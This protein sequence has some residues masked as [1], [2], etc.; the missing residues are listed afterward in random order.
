M[1]ERDRKLFHTVYLLQMG[2]TADAIIWCARN[3]DWVLKWHEDLRPDVDKA[4]KALGK[5]FLQMTLKSDGKIFKR[6]FKAW[7]K[8]QA[9]PASLKELCRT[10]GEG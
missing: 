1:S 8:E 3:T 5:L 2:Q 7:K 4:F 10:R 6:R 9:N